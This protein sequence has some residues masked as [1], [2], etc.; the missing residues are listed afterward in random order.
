MNMNNI[1]TS[2]RS[3]TNLNSQKES[4]P[5]EDPN[6]TCPTTNI[7]QAQ[8]NSSIMKHEHI[9]QLIN[10]RDFA[11]QEA[12]QAKDM[13][14]HVIEAVQILSSQMKKT[15]FD[16]FNDEDFHNNCHANKVPST[17]LSSSNLVIPSMMSDLTSGDMSLRGSSSS[18]N[19]VEEQ[20][21]RHEHEHGQ[22]DQSKSTNNNSSNNSHQITKEH[23]DY[24]TKFLLSSK[25]Q[26]SNQARTSPASSVIYTSEEHQCL[27][28]LLELNSHLSSNFIESEHLSQL[29][30]GLL[31]LSHSCQMVGENATSL[32]NEASS[33]LVDL[34]DANVKLN[35]MQ[36]RCSKLEMV[37][38]KLYKD[39]KNLQRDFVKSKE[40][41][42]SLGDKLKVLLD[43]KESKREYDEHLLKAWYIHERM[44]NVPKQSIANEDSNANDDIPGTPI[45]EGT[46][47]TGITPPS[48]AGFEEMLNNC[49]T[50]TKDSSSNNGKNSA[51]HEKTIIVT[52]Q[53][54]L[55]FVPVLQLSPSES[56]PDSTDV[57]KPTLSS[58]DLQMF[59]ENDD[60]DENDNSFN[61]KETND[62]KKVI[63]GFASSVFNHNP[64]IKLGKS[65]SISSKTSTSPPKPENSFKTMFLSNK[66]KKSIPTARTIDVAP[67]ISVITVTLPKANR[68]SGLNPFMSVAASQ[69][70]NKSDTI[71]SDITNDSTHN[72]IGSNSTKLPTPIGV[73]ARTKKNYKSYSIG[74]Q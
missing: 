63:S 25:R 36:H 11:R 17:Q 33:F 3:S 53:P 7:Q 42:Q 24:L 12:K 19:I 55:S 14:S 51:S 45:D 66:K 26:G 57:I 23:P 73:I 62:K 59:D 74:D 70:I 30:S 47:S 34:Q 40:K 35:K 22:E 28:E 4:H 68:S 13:V 54:W 64:K 46:N 49:S 67:K 48:S 58:K 71:T 52:N 10:E 41:R 61:I 6:F 72:S 44:I 18:H 5:N 1:D 9:Q 69:A 65:A 15:H 2:K 38:K 37:A 39:N 20:D 56:I 29:Q 32:H 27:S 21:H 50:S 60:N 16:M 43:E 8:Y 31:D